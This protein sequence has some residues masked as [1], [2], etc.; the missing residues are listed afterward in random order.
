MNYIVGT[1]P[2]LHN[3]KNGTKSARQIAFW[4]GDSL[5]YC[6]FKKFKRTHGW[7]KFWKK[8]L[9]PFL[10][11]QGINLYRALLLWL[12]IRRA[13]PL[14]CWICYFYS[15]FSSQC[16]LTRH[17]YNNSNLSCTKTKRIN[18]QWWMSAV[19]IRSLEYKT[20]FVISVSCG[21]SWTI[22][23]SH[24]ARIQTKQDVD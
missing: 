21:Y 9:L 23:L 7:S 12:F 6:Q 11:C 20:L 10:L 4:S 22:I 5:I 17:T 8:E 2:K 16:E 14:I 3:C 13:L 1:G 18:Y 19:S 24:F 15:K